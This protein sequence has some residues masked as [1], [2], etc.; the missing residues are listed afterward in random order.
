MRL[1]RSDHEETSVTERDFILFCWRLLAQ[2]PDG[3]DVLWSIAAHKDYWWRWS[4]RA[5]LMV[6]VAKHFKEHHV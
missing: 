5:A 3:F 2:Y 6:T 4:S 1:V